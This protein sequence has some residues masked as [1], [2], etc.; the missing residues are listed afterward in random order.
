M[1]SGVGSQEKHF[2]KLPQVKDTAGCRL[3]ITDPQNG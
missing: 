1:C 2:E 3:Y